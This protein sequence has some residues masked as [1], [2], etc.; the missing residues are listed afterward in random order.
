MPIILSDM[1]VERIVDALK[2]DA[3]P[4]HREEVIA[5]LI[6][7]RE[8]GLPDDIEIYRAI[9]KSRKRKRIDVAR[10]IC[11]YFNNITGKS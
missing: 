4:A 7:A 1:G 10:A 3:D 2:T 6:E 8:Q 11:D 5:G 9:K